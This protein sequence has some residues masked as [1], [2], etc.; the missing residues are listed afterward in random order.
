MSANALLSVSKV[1]ILMDGCLFN[2][3]HFLWKLSHCTVANGSCSNILFFYLHP[4]ALKKT[5]RFVDIKS[6]SKIEEIRIFWWNLQKHTIEKQLSKH[7]Y[8]KMIEMRIF[9]IIWKHVGF[10][11]NFIFRESSSRFTNWIA[12][13]MKILRN[14][15]LWKSWKNRNEKYLRRKSSGW[16]EEQPISY[17]FHLGPIFVTWTSKNLGRLWL[18]LDKRK[19]RLQLA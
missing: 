17:G 8:W 7:V 2:S 12:F 9:M 6:E 3:S 11:I 14:E 1:F 16:W 4:I 15:T 5:K 18:S 19:I 10:V 13:S